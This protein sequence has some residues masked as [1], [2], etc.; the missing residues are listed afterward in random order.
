MKKKLGRF[1]V[2]FLYGVLW[3]AP[4]YYFARDFF[5]LSS[6]EILKESY[7]QDIISFSIKQGFYSTIMA[8][9]VGIV[10][11]YYS[12]YNKDKIYTGISLYSI[13]LSC[14]IDSYNFFSYI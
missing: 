3:L 6:F 1:L 11:A 13:F 8:L 14:N 10:P 7:I 9:I 4:I 5:E 2:N 12:A